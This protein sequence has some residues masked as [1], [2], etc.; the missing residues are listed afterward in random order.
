IR[1]QWVFF[2]LSVVLSALY[3]VMQVADA[4]VL[5]W[6]TDHVVAPS[7]EQGEFLAASVWAGVAL[8]LGA[9]VLRTIGVVGR[10]LLGGI[11][12]Y[13]L[14]RDDRRRVTRKYLQLPLRW[15]HRHPTGQLLS[16]ANADVEATWAVFMPL[17]MAIGVLAMLG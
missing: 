3:G 2:T 11:V 6:V 7:F 16:N 15:H 5:G 9:A 17:P 14:V 10:R 4:W 13:R 12:Y 1:R 8:F